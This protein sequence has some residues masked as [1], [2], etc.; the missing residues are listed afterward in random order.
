MAPQ[1]QVV[2]GSVVPWGEGVVATFQDGLTCCSPPAQS[3]PTL[4]HG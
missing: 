2:L 3:R 1:M 4:N